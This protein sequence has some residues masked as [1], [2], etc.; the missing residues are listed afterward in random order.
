MDFLNKTFAQFSDLFRSMTPG[1]RITAGLLLVVAV[2]SVGY[3]FQSQ[4]GGGDDYLFSGDSIPTA[5]LHKMVGAFGEAD[6]NNFTFEGGRVKVPRA[7]RA[8]Y[9]AALVHAKALPPNFG[10]LLKEAEDGNPFEAPKQRD[11]RV[12]LRKQEAMSMVINCLPGIE[13]AQVII[14]QERRSDGFDLTPLKTAVVQVSAVGGNPLDEEQVE[15]IRDF[16]KG[17][18]AGIKNVTVVD[19]N[20]GS[21][22]WDKDLGDTDSLAYA[23]AEHKAEQYLTAKIRNA[24]RHISGVT[25]TP[26][27]ILDDKKGSRTVEIKNDPKPIPVKTSEN[28]RT[29][30]HESGTVGGAPGLAGQGGGANQPASLGA[31]GG[32]GSNET[33]EESKNE[34]VSVVSQTRS[35]K[36]SFDLIPKMTKAS[37]GIPSSYYEK[38]WKQKNPP[39]E[40]E[41]AKK[42]EA[43]DLEKIAVDV[44][45]SVRA[46]VAP[47]LIPPADDKDPALTSRVTVTTFEDIKAAEIH[48]PPVTQRAL[49]WLGQNWPMMAM[50]GLVLFSLGVLRTTLRSVP[51]PAAESTTVSMRVAASESKS[52]EEDTIEATAARRLR[53]MSGSGP[54]LRDELS[55]LVKEDPDSAANV[56][57]SWI[58]QVS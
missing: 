55:E 31:N 6:L 30:T 42:P 34:T 29:S 20:G 47:V 4:V 57:R 33:S 49:T 12:Q 50:L 26:L 2:V 51:A 32:K 24:L 46:M 18:I 10:D 35:E 36:E 37:I 58:G 52:E 54:S 8:K 7:Q 41:D 16:V 45:K 40:G 15:K 13:T 56:L 39:K 43:A 9:L 14:D 44:A 23:R 25:V 27:V 3:L 28:S 53:R 11:E 17:G 38:V 1:G 21:Y 22:K 19:G 5:T 48:G